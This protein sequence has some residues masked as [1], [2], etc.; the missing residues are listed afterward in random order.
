MYKTVRDF[1]YEVPGSQE[2]NDLLAI[3]ERIPAQYQQLAVSSSSFYANCIS[4]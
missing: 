1:A 2:K 4:C 3:L